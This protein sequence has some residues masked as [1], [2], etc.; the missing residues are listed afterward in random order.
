MKPSVKITIFVIFLSTLVLLFLS[1]AYLSQQQTK[2]MPPTFSTISP[3]PLPKPLAQGIY[4]NPFDTK[5]SQTTRIVYPIKELN[6]CQ[7][8]KA[9]FDYCSIPQNNP[10]CWSYGTY[11]LRKE[12]LGTATSSGTLKE[13]TV[14]CES[15]STCKS[16]CQINPNEC[17]GYAEGEKNYLGPNGCQTDQECQMYCQAHPSLCP[18]FPAPKPTKLPTP[19]EPVSS[20][21]GVMCTQEA[22]LC[23]DG[24]Y[25]GRTGPNCEFT[26]C[27]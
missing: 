1:S 21:S 19:T 17:P 18:G 24:S 11:I 27:P 23:P 15:D 16:Y 20:D 26:P 3:T 13:D 25:V 10:A 22:K 8:Q 4:H 2:P 7:D 12:V 6:S 9:C 14:S 5:V